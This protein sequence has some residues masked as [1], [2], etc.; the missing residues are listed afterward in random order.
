MAGSLWSSTSEFL[1]IPDNLLGSSWIDVGVLD[2]GTW[3]MGPDVGET[4]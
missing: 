1:R 2:V 3:Q 4:R